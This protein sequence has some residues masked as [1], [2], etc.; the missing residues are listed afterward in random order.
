MKYML[1]K[2]EV[3]CTVSKGIVNGASFKASPEVQQRAFP[4]SLLQSGSAKL[5]RNLDPISRV[6]LLRGNSGCF[7]VLH[8][9]VSAPV[10]PFTVINACVN[11]LLL[12]LR[13]MDCS[14]RSCSPCT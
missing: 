5:T 2:C 11:S 1:T 8:T 13:L 10:W 14:A 7:L 4:D 12:L 3:A 9:K 6:R